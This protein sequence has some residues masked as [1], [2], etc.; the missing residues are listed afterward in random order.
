MKTFEEKL[1]DLSVSLNGELY[2]HE[3]EGGYWL[4]DPVET[5]STIEDF[6][7]SC[8]EWRER[9]DHVCG[10]I[11]GMDYI[12]W[13]EVQVRKGDQRDALLV[14]DFGDRRLAFRHDISNLDLD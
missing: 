8:R 4:V 11:A 5:K 10:T 7:V 14:I 12:F 6:L 13:E 1:V 3:Y 9:T 2:D